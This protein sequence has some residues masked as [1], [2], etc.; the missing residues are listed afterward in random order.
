MMDAESRQKRDAADV[1]ASGMKHY[2]ASAVAF[3]TQN[4]CGKLLASHHTNVDFIG[5][6]TAQTGVNRWPRSR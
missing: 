3:F 4:R 6:M 5:A 1:V 2:R